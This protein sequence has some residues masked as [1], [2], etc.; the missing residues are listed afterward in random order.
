MADRTQGG[1]ET[2][3]LLLV[4]WPDDYDDEFAR[5]AQDAEAMRFISG[6][7]PLTLEEIT[8]I[9]RRSRAMWDEYG[10][11]PWAAVDKESGRWVGRIG[12]NLLADWPGPDKWEV[13]FELAPEFWGRGLA[14]EGAREAI[15]FGWARTPLQRIISATAAGHLAS[16]R[17]MEKCGL[18]YQ[19]EIAFRTA[20]VA[21]YAIDRPGSA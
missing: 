18:A 7:R 13:G 6:G 4:P 2:E 5:V 1:A 8:S 16:R 10:Y 14:T 3:R 21:W 15:R 17:V 12:L 11:G 19:G 9:T 20:R